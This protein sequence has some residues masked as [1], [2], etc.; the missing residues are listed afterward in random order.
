MRSTNIASTRAIKINRCVLMRFI[1]VFMACVRKFVKMFML[2]LLSKKM[3]FL[4]NR[5]YHFHQQMI[6]ALWFV[7]AYDNLDDRKR[8]CV[9]T[10]SLTY[11]WLNLPFNIFILLKHVCS[12]TLCTKMNEWKKNAVFFFFITP[13]VSV[14]LSLNVYN[15]YAGCSSVKMKTLFFLSFLFFYGSSSII[16]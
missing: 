10:R 9:L 12:A 13:I 5:L 7:Y 3:K 1:L 11:Y 14:K 2:E 16:R 6:T 15:N 8:V 4:N